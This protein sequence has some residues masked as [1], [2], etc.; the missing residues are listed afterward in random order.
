MSNPVQGV[1]GTNPYA[2][3][4]VKPAAPARV[5]PVAPLYHVKGWLKLIGWVYI[6]LGVLQCLT[7]VYAIVGWLPIWVGVLC[8]KAS[9]NLEAGYQNRNSAQL[10]EATSNIAT[11]IKIIGVVTMIYLVMAAIAIVFLVILLI[12]GGIAGLSA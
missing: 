5:D 1:P 8:N 4:G 3:A 10:Q 2:S 7:I 9:S 12:G 11:I 6:V